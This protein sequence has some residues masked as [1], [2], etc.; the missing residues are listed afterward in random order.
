MIISGV[1]APQ[2][3]DVDYSVELRTDIGKRARAS[4]CMDF[5]P[6]KVER[7]KNESAVYAANNP[8]FTALV[9]VVGYGLVIMEKESTAIQGIHA[10][11]KFIPD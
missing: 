9:D 1:F 7:S 8:Y 5:M 4:G 2:D 3:P 6:R 11:V 10:W